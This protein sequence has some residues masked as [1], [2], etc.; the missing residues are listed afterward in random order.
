MASSARSRRQRLDERVVDGHLHAQRQAHVKH[1]PTDRAAAVE[2]EPEPSQ[3]RRVVLPD[4][5]VG[6]TVTQAVERHQLQVEVQQHGQRLPGDFLSGGSAPIR[7]PHALF[8]QGTGEVG[9]KYAA[10]VADVLQS[11]A[12]PG[13]RDNV[14]PADP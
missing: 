8:H 9:L 13:H 7:D 3:L 10:G 14:D 1:A 5:G 2:P 4:P 12:T 11:T 6:F